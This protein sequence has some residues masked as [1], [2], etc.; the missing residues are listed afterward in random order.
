MSLSRDFKTPFLGHWPHFSA[1]RA[2]CHVLPISHYKTMPYSSDSFKINQI[3]NISINSIATKEEVIFLYKAI[4]H[5]K[6]LTNE[7]ELYRKQL[8]KL[9]Q[10]RIQ[11]E[12]HEFIIQVSV[13]LSTIYGLNVLPIVIYQNISKLKYNSSLKKTPT[14]VDLQW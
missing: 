8:S 3:S 5:L 4:L 2:V 12:N 10:N 11:V 6:W 9:E 1:S 7:P 13:F 14:L